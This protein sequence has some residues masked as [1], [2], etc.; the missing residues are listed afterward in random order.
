MNKIDHLKLRKI[1]SEVFPEDDRPIIIQSGLWSFV[2]LLDCSIQ[3]SAKYTLD[4]I[5]D[6]FNDEKTILMPSFTPN[7]STT[8][9][10]DIYLS[11]PTTGILPQYAIKE[12]IMT[13]TLQ[14]M[15]SFIVRGKC[16]EEV[17][18]LSCTTVWGKDSIMEWIEKKDAIW[19]AFGVPWSI[20]CAFFHRA[21]EIMRVP[22]RYYKKYNGKCF[23]N[24]KFLGEI[25]EVKYS[26][27]KK[28]KP[29]F[30]FEAWPKYLYQ[31][32]K[33]KQS[34]TKYLFIET[35]SAKTILQAALNFFSDDMYAFIKNKKEVN[36]WVENGKN[37]E[38]ENLDKKEKVIFT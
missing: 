33:V 22:Y 25:S 18:G 6:F 17:K 32:G 37:K 28:I 29:I 27:S 10:F 20:G 12:K 23:N 30:N 21:E 38:I 35:A 19:C 7:F 4:F 13:R 26:Y 15:T 3:D 34:K 36:A 2:R 16:E 24:K 1:F 5:L 14:P 8:K 11:K 31:T 9:K